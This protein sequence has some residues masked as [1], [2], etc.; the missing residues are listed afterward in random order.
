MNRVREERANSS[1]MG[2]LCPTLVPSTETFS[3]RRSK[4]RAMREETSTLAERK[5]SFR[6]AFTSKV[7]MQMNS[8]SPPSAEQQDCMKW[9]RGVT[10]QPELKL[11]MLIKT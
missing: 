7:M 5:S 1:K 2:E 3:S 8:S 11:A 10:I 9:R 4:Q 6:T